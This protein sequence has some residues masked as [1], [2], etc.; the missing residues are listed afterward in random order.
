MC[1]SRCHRGRCEISCCGVCFLR[2]G[3]KYRLIRS[4]AVVVYGLRSFSTSRSSGLNHKYTLP[5]ELH[6]AR[7]PFFLPDMESPSLASVEIAPNSHRVKSAPVLTFPHTSGLQDQV[8]FAG[9][10][11]CSKSTFTH[12]ISLVLQMKNSSAPLPVH[13]HPAL[14]NKL[15]F[16]TR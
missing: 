8:L 13:F 12:R 2:T 9:H 1:G 3:R 4:H 14:Q 16:R 15:C 10:P 11:L 5:K 7:D 6:I